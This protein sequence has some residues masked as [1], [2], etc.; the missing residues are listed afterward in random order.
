MIM[1]LTK[2]TFA[3]NLKLV[4]VKICEIVEGREEI[5]FIFLFFKV[6]MFPGF[7]WERH[8]SLVV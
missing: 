2:S 6:A 5:V 8:Q 7:S 4:S 3:K 1:I